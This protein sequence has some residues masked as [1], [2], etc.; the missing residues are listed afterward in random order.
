MRSSVR[1][2]MAGELPRC[3]RQPE[4]WRRGS[5]EV[6]LLRSA[7]DTQI[8][9]RQVP[10]ACAG[11]RDIGHPFAVRLSPDEDVA[12]DKDGGNDAAF[13]LFG[14]EIDEGAY[15][16]EDEPEEQGPVIHWNSKDSN[17]DLRR[18]TRGWLLS[19]ACGRGVLPFELLPRH[20]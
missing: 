20:S 1:W 8:S 4:R 6:A 3:W 16:D 12:P 10:S 18:C 17:L 14:S 7:A 9:R 11:P 2:R 15:N 19:D 5:A 13:L